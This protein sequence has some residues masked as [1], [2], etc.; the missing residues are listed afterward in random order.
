MRTCTCLAVISEYVLSHTSVATPSRSLTISP[1]LLTH[2]T[3]P[4][5]SNRPSPFT[6]CSAS[7]TPPSLLGVVST[8]LN[9]TFASSQQNAHF[10]RLPCYASRPQPSPTVTEMGC[11]WMAPAD[12]VSRSSLSSCP[13]IS[14]AF[15]SRMAEGTS[16]EKVAAIAA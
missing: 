1:L 8:T 5:R 6:L 4:H 2:P 7:T 9:R 12:S 11:S 3:H 16:V 10:T 14:G 15:R 13:G